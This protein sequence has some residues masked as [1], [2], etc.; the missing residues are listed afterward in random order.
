MSNIKVRNAPRLKLS[1]LLRRRK[2]TLKLFMDEFGITTYEALAI[3]CKRLGVQPPDESAFV[4]LNMPLVS[5]PT[6]GVIVLAIEPEQDD[7]PRIRNGLV[8]QLVVEEQDNL[9]VT[10]GT[11]KKQRKKKESLPTDE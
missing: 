6:E 9:E 8:Q 4:A 5:S 10:E 3:R 2:M 1:D 11:Q 7:V